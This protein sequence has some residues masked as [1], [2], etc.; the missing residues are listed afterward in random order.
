MCVC[1]L[2]GCAHTCVCEGPWPHV[3]GCTKVDVHVCVCVCVRAWS[4]HTYTRARV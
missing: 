3:L 1:V 4:T 2:G